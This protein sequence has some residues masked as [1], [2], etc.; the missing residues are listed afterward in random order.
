MILSR[1]IRKIETATLELKLYD[2]GLLRG[3]RK[4]RQPLTEEDKAE[5]WR[6]ADTPPPAITV[7]DILS[8]FP[9]SKVVVKPGPPCRACGQPVSLEQDELDGK[10]YQNLWMHRCRR[11]VR[12]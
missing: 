8:A 5:A 11:K 9:G 2:D 10:F 7:A 4:D 1:E 12:Q 6:L 3:R